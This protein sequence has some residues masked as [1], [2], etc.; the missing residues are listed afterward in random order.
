MIVLNSFIQLKTNFI[1]L[2]K[3]FIWTVKFS[4]NIYVF[5]QDLLIMNSSPWPPTETTARGSLLSNS[6]PMTQS[7]KGLN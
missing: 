4:S 5:L 7:I 6:F 1:V 2:V 3:C